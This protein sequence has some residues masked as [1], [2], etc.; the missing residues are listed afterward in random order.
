MKKFWISSGTD[1]LNFQSILFRIFQRFVLMVPGFLEISSGTNRIL[2][3][4]HSWRYLRMARIAGDYIE[5][6]VYEGLTFEL[7]LMSAGKYFS[8]KS[9]E[10]PRF[11]AFDSFCGLPSPDASRDSTFFREGAYS[12][13]LDKF[14]R[15]ISHAA[16]GWDVRIIPGFYEKSLN[17]DILKEHSLKAAAFVNVDCDLYNSARIVLQFITPVLQNGTI[18]YFDDWYFSRGDRTLGEMGAC[19]DW[20]K[21]NPQISLLPY[22]D[23]GTMGKLFI[24]GISN[25]R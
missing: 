16:R 1:F 23:V 7:A 12:A 21:E 2:A 15:K 14:K 13:S 11:F 18:L 4:L 5:F 20:L 19:N 10:A 25:H 6:G 24:V 8:K 3:F 17:P 9:L 22:R